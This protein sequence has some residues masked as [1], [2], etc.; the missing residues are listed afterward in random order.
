MTP[1]LAEQRVRSLDA[2]R[3]AT[4]AGMILV[5]DP[6]SWADSYAQLKHAAWSGWTATDMVFPFFL[7][8]MGV[9]MIFSFAKRLEAGATKRSLLGHAVRRSAIIFMIGL[10]LNA[11]PFGVGAPFS[12]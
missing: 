8:I 1:S 4:I 5:N 9:A 6:G 3:G 2:F 7:W 12:F 11:F 10:L